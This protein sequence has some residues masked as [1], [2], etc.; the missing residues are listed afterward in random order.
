M[1]RLI[2]AIVLTCIPFVGF[3]QKPLEFSTI[4][5]QDSLSAQELYE[6]TR[7]WIAESYVNNKAVV[8][9]DNPGKQITGKGSIKFSTSMMYSSIDGFIEYL[10]DIQFRDGR[11]KLSMRNFTHT[12]GHKALYDNNMGVLVDSLPSNLSTI[13]ITG[14]RK[15]SYKY[16]F[17]NGTPLCKETFD[18]I[19]NSLSGF[20][21]KR[22]V[23]AKDEW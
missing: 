19:V 15:A 16:Y 5:R 1:K 7:N 22:Q 14:Q 4:I 8:R 10:L 21:N 12:A 13:G 20:L 17:K 3:A 11:L 9:D 18:T 23:A 6:A 2:F